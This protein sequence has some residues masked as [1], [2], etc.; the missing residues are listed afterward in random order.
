MLKCLRLG[1]FHFLRLTRQVRMKNFDQNLLLLFKLLKNTCYILSSYYF[2]NSSH[3]SSSVVFWKN[4]RIRSF[5]PKVLGTLFIC[6]CCFTKKICII[7]WVSWLLA[8]S[9]LLFY[10]K[11]FYRLGKVNFAFFMKSKLWLVCVIITI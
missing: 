6:S 7:I 1:K 4:S 8:F 5:K 2:I 11:T 9:W 3:G 10:F